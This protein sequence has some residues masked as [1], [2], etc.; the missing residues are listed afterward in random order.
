VQGFPNSVI[1]VR[2]D[3]R[4]RLVANL[5]RFLKRHPVAN[6]APGDFEPDGTWY[7]MVTYR[8]ALYALEPN[9]GELDRITRRGRV[10][11][12][13]DV[14]LLFG[15]VVPTALAVDPR[16]HRFYIGTLTTFP[17]A[18][19]AAQVLV[20]TPQGRVTRIISG[21]TAIVGLAVRRHQLWVLETSSVAG[22]PQ[23]GTGTIIRL[24]R[25]GRR[26]VVSGL[27]FPTAMT[28]GPKGDLYV[29]NKG[30]GFPRGA[31]EVLRVRR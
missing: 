21:F 17:L 24:T 5:S 28:F 2:R 29:T 20:V 11:R 4:W 1:R 14:S 9:H 23:P 7:S 18:P 3:G 27:T 26:T 22:F 25:R 19:G 31:G 10:S 12:V 16:R 13:L 15:H 6:P 30:F 8:G